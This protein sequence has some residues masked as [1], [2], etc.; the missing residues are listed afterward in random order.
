MIGIYK[1][2]NPTNK[3]YIG[4]SVN[5]QGRIYKYQSLRCKSQR[6]IYASILKYGWDNHKLEVLC[7][8]EIDELNEKERY[9]QDLYQAIGTKGLNCILTT[10]ETKSG[11]ARESTISKLKG[12]KLSDETKEKM[13]NKIITNEHKQNISNGLKGKIVSEETKIKISQANK[14]KIRSKECIIEIKK[15]VISEETKTKISVAKTGIKLSKE[16]KEKLSEARKGFK[17]SEKWIEKIK[18]RNSKE[19][20]DTKTGIIYN[21]ITEVSKIFDI[22]R[23]TLNAKLSGQNKNDTFFVYYI[24]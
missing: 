21:S 19:I 15:R 10:T 18:K 8:C 13:R 17:K 1:I 6:I 2:T 7:E 16:H 20:I 4:Q 5:I 9:Y 11:K 22:N 14:G 12:R 23:K 24:K 3:I